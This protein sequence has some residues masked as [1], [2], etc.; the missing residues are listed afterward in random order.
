[1]KRRSVLAGIV[2]GAAGAAAWPVLGTA[3]GAAGL[4]AGARPLQF[5]SPEDELRAFIRMKGATDPVDAPL[6]YFGTLYAQLPD[7][8][9]TP[10]LGFQGLELARFERQPDG[11]YRTYETMT[12]V[13]ADP[14]TGEFIDEFRNPLTGKVN[15]VVSNSGGGEAYE[16]ATTH[17]QPMFGKYTRPG[18]GLG[19]KWAATPTHVWMSYPRTYPDV[20]PQPSS[21]Y[22]TMHATRADFEGRGRY[23][24]A[25]FFSTTVLPWFK[26]LEMG[27]RP[28]WTLWHANGYKF[29]SLAEVPR[30]LIARLEQ[31]HPQALQTPPSRKA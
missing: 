16:Y 15:Q 13:F 22:I 9:S 5:A 26:W 19:A 25:T 29:R 11:A 1:M 24:P 7:G 23:V 28:G 30:P 6:W 10:L 3:A 27:D 18:T 12:T 2:Q 21:E 20:W 31:R 14:V 4:P 8:R 17:A